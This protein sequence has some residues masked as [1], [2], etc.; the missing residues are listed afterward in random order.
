[1]RDRSLPK[2]SNT[3]PLDNGR[4]VSVIIPL[5]NRASLI[6]HTLRSLASEHHPGVSLQVIVVDDGS[7]DRGPEIVANQ[8][9]WV[10]LVRSD[11]LGAPA[12]RNLGLSRAVG[13]TVLYLDSDDL[14][15]PHFFESRLR[16]LDICHQAAGAYGP[17]KVFASNGAYSTE[18]LQPRH[19][20]YPTVEQLD[21]DEHLLR[22]LRGW[23]I[24]GCAILWRT[25]AI[26]AA[27][28]HDHR[29]H[30]NQDVDLCFRVLLSTSGIIGVNGPPALV[31]YHAGARQ[32]QVINGNQVA[33]IAALRQRFRRALAS[34]GRLNDTFRRALA[35]YAF[36]SWAAW[37]SIAPEHADELLTLSREL[38]PSLSV[39]GG[40]MYRALGWLLGPA[41]AVMLKQRWR[42]LRHSS[43]SS[44]V[45]ENRTR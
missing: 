40:A 39:R 45:I 34:S 11:H 15:A 18:A 33:Q 13:R 37:R 35:E 43:L 29:L 4:D 1:M 27:G 24:A 14:V 26:R 42:Q 41:N 22:L 19:A 8:F 25:D 38:L 3:N 32:G 44:G 6:P 28:G 36:D 16:T 30:I 31:R 2:R 7:F 12:A 17:W 21:A 10:S 5:Y 20:E 9:Q 23:Y